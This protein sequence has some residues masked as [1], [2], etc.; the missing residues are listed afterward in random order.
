MDLSYSF[1]SDVYCTCGTITAG[2]QTTVAAAGSSSTFCPS[3]AQDPNVVVPTIVSA[4]T[5]ANPQSTATSISATSSTP[6]ECTKF[7]FL[8]EEDS[9]SFV[10][11]CKDGTWNHRK[12][13]ESY[14]DCPNQVAS[15]SLTTTSSGAIIPTSVACS[16]VVFGPGSPYWGPPFFEC[17]NG[18][19]I[20]GPPYP[21]T[22]SARTTTLTLSEPNTSG[23]KAFFPITTPLTAVSD[24]LCLRPLRLELPSAW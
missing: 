21:S 16:V 7:W 22:L 2:I 24:P 4:A 15:T 5:T 3:T 14:S 10:C 12:A 6:A 20:L 19:L 13:Q 11:Q 18:V 23:T 8:S 9:N 17:D 1:G